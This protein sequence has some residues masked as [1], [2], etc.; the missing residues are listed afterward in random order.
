MLTA[1]RRSVAFCLLMALAGAH[2]QADTPRLALIIDDIGYS[3]ERGRR[4]IALPGPVTLAVLPFTPNANALAALAS[5][6]GQDV[7]LHQPMESIYADARPA[8]ATL[9]T[10]M[11]W[12][13]FHRT[14]GLA[15]DFLPQAIGVSNHTGSLLTAR[16]EQMAWLMNEVGARGLFFVDSRTTAET[17]ALDTATRIGVPSLRRDVFLDHDLDPSAMTHHFERAVTIARTKGHAVVIAHPHDESLAFLERSLPAL[18]ARGVAQTR[19][20]ELVSSGAGA[21]R[22]PSRAAPG[23]P[24]NPTS[25]RTGPAL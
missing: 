5:E 16:S 12:A 22:K 17:V 10:E 2:A 20:A 23:L 3:L 19:V 1:R 13:S 21:A 24:R 25:P 6:R 9:T 15:L 11:P 7:I 14:L 4:A 8:P 18:A